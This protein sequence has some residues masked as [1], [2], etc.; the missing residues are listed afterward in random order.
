MRAEAAE[1]YGAMDM[2]HGPNLLAR[3]PEG[4]P[5]SKTTSEEAFSPTADIEF[6]VLLSD[7]GVITPI[8]AECD[9]RL[10]YE[11]TGAK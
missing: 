8:T 2:A 3:S 7:S 9:K 5:K 1:V 6:P 10:A 4:L 11:I